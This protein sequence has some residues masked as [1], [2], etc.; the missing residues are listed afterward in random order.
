MSHSCGVWKAKIKVPFYES[1]SGEGP[2]SCGQIQ[3]ANCRELS[4]VSPSEGT[5][6]IPGCYTLRLVT[7]QHH[8]T[9][10]L[11]SSMR[12]L[13]GTQSVTVL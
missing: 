7:S 8:H 2:P 5:N 3:T 13:G 9:G 12:V 11:G 10:G 4:P 6:P 1:R